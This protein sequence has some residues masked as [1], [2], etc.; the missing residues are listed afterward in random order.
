M[1]RDYAVAALAVL[2]LLAVSL[3]GDHAPKP[4][5]STRASGDLSFGGYRAWY[6]LLADEGVRVEQFRRYHDGL[7]DSGI[8]TLIVAFP[9]VL[10]PHVWNATERD[11]LRAWVR[12]GGHLVDIGLTPEADKNDGKDERVFLDYTR[13]DRGRLSG[14]WSPLVGALPE[15]GIERLVPMKH[16]RVETLLRDKAGALV[17]RYRYGRGEVTGVW[18]ATPFENRAI[19]RGDAARLAYLIARPRRTGGAV[20]FDALAVV[21]ILSLQAEE[22][23]AEFGRLCFRSSPGGY[24]LFSRNLHAVEDFLSLGQ[25][26]LGCCVAPGGSGVG[27]SCRSLGVAGGTGLRVNLAV[28]PDNRLLLTGSF[29][30]VLLAPVAGR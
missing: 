21:D 20:A 10:V 12:Y 2:A 4:P 16:A 9:D 29:T 14:A 3:L 27:I 5:G 13:G 1:R 6:E 17:V 30:L 24:R 18:N 11:A 8:D 26:V 22:V 19:G 15:R 23:V 25:C 28:V 7:A